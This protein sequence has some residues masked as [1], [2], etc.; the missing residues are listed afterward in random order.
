MT[1]Q[2]GTAPQSAVKFKP[3]ASGNPRGPIKSL[4]PARRALARELG[5]NA[6]EIVSTT[7][8]LALAGDGACAAALVTIIASG[9]EAPASNKSAAAGP[10]A[11]SVLP[12]D[13]D[14]GAE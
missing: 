13:V 8:R 5:D 7:I 2:A 6:A 3:G 4:T 11:R 14:G 9:F 1:F 12:I 10:G